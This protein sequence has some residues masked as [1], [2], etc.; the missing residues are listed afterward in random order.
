MTDNSLTVM[1]V[2]KLLSMNDIE[3]S[4]DIIQKEYPFTYTKGGKRA[5]SLKQVLAIFIRDGFIDRYSGKK[6]I[7][8]GA[9]K[10]LSNIFPEDFPY[11]QHGKM[12]ECHIAYWEL[13]PT[14]DHILPITKGGKDD[15]SNLIC[16]SMLKNS[17]KANF[18]IDE[19]GW[20]ILPAGDYREWDGMLTWFV[21]Y[22]SNNLDLLDDGYIKKWFKATNRIENV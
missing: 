1:K 18:T 11:H 4:R 17:A 9:L 7:F 6:L 16:T 3:A 22:V 12:D 10:V 19:L 15:E 20:S 8:P 13:I 14:I 5:Y 21:E 2:C